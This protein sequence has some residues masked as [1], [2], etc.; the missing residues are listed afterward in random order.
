MHWQQKQRHYKHFM[1]P[2]W[3]FLTVYGGVA[4]FTLTVKINLKYI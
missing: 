1:H 2:Q 4:W 3:V